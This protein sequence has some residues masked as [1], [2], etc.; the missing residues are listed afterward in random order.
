MARDEY[1][2]IFGG[3]LYPAFR[4][5]DVE[6]EFIRMMDHF[7]ELKFPYPIRFEGEDA[8]VIGETMGY[9]RMGKGENDNAN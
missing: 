4:N 8:E 6:W 3:V 9:F 2:A 1:D 7:G 5:Y